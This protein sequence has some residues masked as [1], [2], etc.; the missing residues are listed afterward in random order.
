MKKSIVFAL[1][2]LLAICL[3]GCGGEPE[4]ARPI[5]QITITRIPI[6][7]PVYD[8]NGEVTTTYPTGKVY[9]NASNSQSENDPPVAMGVVELTPAMMVGSTYTVTIDLRE[10]VDPPGSDPDDPS[11]PWNGTARFFSV[12]I[13]PQDLHGLGAQAIEVRASIGLNHRSEQI[14]W[15][16]FTMNLSKL[17]DDPFYQSKV[18]TLY[19]AIV[20]NDTDYITQ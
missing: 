11:A 4:E 6:G 17:Y 9:L 15:D 3:T 5:E 16:S 8:A 20:S 10:P 19:I 1:G 12:V 13:S 14:S 7:V 2:L 18:D